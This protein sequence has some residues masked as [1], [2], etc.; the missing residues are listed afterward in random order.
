MPRDGRVVRARL[1]Q[2]ALDLFVEHGFDE[3]T[4][5]A[6]AE[7]AGVTER[8]FF[9]HFTDKRE[10]FF[11]GEREL[12]EVLT[13]A[14]AEIPPD[15]DAMPTLLA[16]FHAAVPLLERNRPLALARADVIRATPALLERELA[17]SVG[18]I[19][20]LT[21]ALE[22][23]GVDRRA[24]RFTAQVGK[25]LYGIAVRRWNETRSDDLHGEIDAAFAELR[26]TAASLG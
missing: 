16:A 2:A 14:F 8:T 17:K 18:L 11:D 23:R 22:Q 4:A 6:I 12:R 10:V 21:E 7:R 15:L 1:Q 5:A 24:A 26:A 19:D 20:M 3:T 9:R 13:E 25:D